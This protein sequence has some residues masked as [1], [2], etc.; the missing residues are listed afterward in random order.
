[1]LFGGLGVVDDSEPSFVSACAFGPDADDAVGTCR[2]DDPD[3]ATLVP[4]ARSPTPL[5]AGPFLDLL[6]RYG[7]DCDEFLALEEVT[8]VGGRDGDDD[9]GEAL[10]QAEGGDGGFYFGRE[11]EWGAEEGDEVVRRCFPLARSGGSSVWGSGRGRER[12]TRSRGEA[13]RAGGRDAV[14]DPPAR[15]RCE[16]VHGGACLTV[17]VPEGWK[18]ERDRVPSRRG[19]GG[20]SPQVGLGTALT[21]CRV[22]NH[23][24]QGKL[25]FTRV[26]QLTQTSP[27]PSHPCSSLT[28]S[29]SSSLSLSLA[30]THARQRDAEWPTEKG[31]EDG[32]QHLPR[33]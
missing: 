8:V 2:F 17:S 18:S 27:T 10:V 6:L 3:S 4:L 23:G 26:C 32:S 22:G 21:R 31:T 29:S 11:V 19:K 16:A 28:S 1:M 15:R 33:G 20:T 14:C 5:G 25:P 12:R 13:A 9:A 7:P 24:T 30:P